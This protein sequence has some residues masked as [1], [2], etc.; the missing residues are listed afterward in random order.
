[1]SLRVGVSSWSTTPSEPAAL[2]LGARRWSVVSSSVESAEAGEVAD[3]NEMLSRFSSVLV[4]PCEPGRL[5]QPEEEARRPGSAMLLAAVRC[6]KTKA[7]AALA[8][9]ARLAEAEDDEQGYG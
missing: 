5:C 4:S 3:R 7:E 6:G 9:A 1:M 8:E 2:R